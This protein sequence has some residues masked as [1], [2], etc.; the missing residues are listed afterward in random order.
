MKPSTSLWTSPVAS[1][2]FVASNETEFSQWGHLAMVPRMSNDS[3]AQQWSKAIC[4]IGLILMKAPPDST[5]TLGRLGVSLQS[6]Q[7]ERFAILHDTAF[8]L[9]RHRPSCPHDV[10]LHPR[11]DRRG[12][13]SPKHPLLP[14]RTSYGLC[15]PS[16]RVWS[17]PSS[18][19]SPG[20]GVP[21]SASERRSPSS[22]AMACTCEP[23]MEGKPRTTGSMR[24]RSRVFSVEA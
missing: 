20:S 24:V 6:H 16:G 21:T 23:S 5:Q 15:G 8:P 2:F 1:S 12:G 19:S 14:P 10:P 9:L 22:L 7:D 13:P 3:G 17:W 4:C 11:F 18:A